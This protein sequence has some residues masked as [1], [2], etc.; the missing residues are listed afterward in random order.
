MIF[1]FQGTQTHQSKHNTGSKKE[2]DEYIILNVNTN[3]NLTVFS[4]WLPGS[5]MGSSEIKTRSHER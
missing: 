2:I 3:V 1:S 5:E 4:H